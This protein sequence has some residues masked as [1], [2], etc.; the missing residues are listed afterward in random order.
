MYG[1]WMITQGEES[2]MSASRFIT[3]TFLLSTTSSLQ[4]ATTFFSRK[5]ATAVQSLARRYSQ[6]TRCLSSWSKSKVMVFLPSLIALSGAADESGLSDTLSIG[7]D[8]SMIDPG[9]SVGDAFES[10]IDQ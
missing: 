5:D 10:S 6:N 2:N 7:I 1:L 9:Q 4:Y 8:R 3:R